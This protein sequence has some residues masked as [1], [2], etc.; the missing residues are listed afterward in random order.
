MTV[1]FEQLAERVAM[2]EL[3]EDVAAVWRAIFG[4][5]AKWLASRIKDFDMTAENVLAELAKLDCSGRERAFKTILRN[6]T[7]HGGILAHGSGLLKH[8]ENGK[9][10]KSRWYADTLWERITSISGVRERF[11]FFQEDGIAFIAQ[12]ATCP[13]NVFFI[14]PPYTAGGSGK[15]AGK[16]LYN[17]SEL[18]H[19]RLF[20]V[21]A[22][23]NGD[24]LMTYD[25][26]PEV[27]AMAAKR[28]F[29]TQ[30]VPMKNTHHA[31]MTEL[32]IGR[33]LNWA[34]NRPQT[35]PNR[36]LFG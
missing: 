1:G 19:D 9:G 28:G 24:F 35:A 36:L 34:R 21:V 29:D 31:E 8:G 12:R 22:Q 27:V 17:H 30:P 16:R 2:V 33:N 7:F 18:D 5:D 15:R 32:L 20:D 6:R 10:V 4:E 23:I 3:D 25:N 14:D 13:T 11:E 26:D